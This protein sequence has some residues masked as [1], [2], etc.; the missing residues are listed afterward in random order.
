ME[1]AGDGGWNLLAGPADAVKHRLVPAYR[2]MHDDGAFPGYSVEPYVPTI[3]DLVRQSGAQ[4]LLDY[5]CGKGLQYTK[6][7]W[8]KAWGIMPTLYDPAVPAF[9]RK[10]KGQFD[11][12]ICTDVL[13]HVPEDELSVVIGDLVRYAK[14]WC[15]VSVC[16]RKA[17]RYKQ[18]PGGGNVHVT[19]RPAEWWQE[20]LG[21]ALVG[22][23]QLHLRVTP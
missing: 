17:K 4:T 23:A 18:L 13:E 8:H 16:C 20:R 9:Y 14:L 3:S 22:H 10:P 15:F 7:G 6:R 19:I 11:G 21:N 1:L 12:V 5:G 2:V